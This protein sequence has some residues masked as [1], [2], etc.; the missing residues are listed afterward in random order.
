MGGVGQSPHFGRGVGGSAGGVHS[1]FP[2]HFGGGGGFM[3]ATSQP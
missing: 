1:G 2:P 3:G